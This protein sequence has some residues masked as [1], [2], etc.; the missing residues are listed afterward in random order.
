M[1]ASRVLLGNDWMDTYLQS[2]IWRFALL[3]GV[4]DEQI[5]MG[6][7]MPSVDKVG[8][9]FPLTIALPL[10][11]ASPTLANVTGAQPWY[12]KLEQIALS[13]L[14]IDQPADQLDQQLLANPYPQ[15]MIGLEDPQARS[16]ADWWQGAG[17]S[18]SF[19]LPAMDALPRI[20]IWAGQ[21][22][23]ASMGRGRSM[24]WSGPP[25]G[26]GGQLWCFSGLPNDQAFVQLLADH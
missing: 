18:G 15:S 20:L 7:L 16:L 25:D 23:A 4:I 19:Q 26:I 14:S 24:W 13:T 6:V 8:R 5:W 11:M 10:N 21:S 2:P 3:P 1:A 22:L 9:Q 17:Q 12:A